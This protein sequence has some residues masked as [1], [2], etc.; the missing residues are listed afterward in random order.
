MKV[1]FVCNMG[2][3]RSPT[4]AKLWKE[5]YNDETDYIGIYRENIKDKVEKADLIIVM[6]PHQRKFIGERFPKEYMKKKIICLDIPDLYS[7]GNIELIKTLKEKFKDIK[8]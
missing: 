2:M 4:A 7:K 3:N 5:M 6:E 8:K 1:L